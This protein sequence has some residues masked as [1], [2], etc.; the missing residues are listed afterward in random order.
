MQREAVVRT[1]ERHREELRARGVTAVAVVGSTARGEAGGASDV[2]LLVDLDP[3]RRPDAF[4]VMDLRDHLRRLLGRPVDVIVRG[5][6]R[7]KV[8]E[9]LQRDAVDVF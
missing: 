3:A 8:R 9:A 4:D 6:L 7:P 1:L 5:G 2:D